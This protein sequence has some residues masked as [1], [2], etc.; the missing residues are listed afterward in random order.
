[1]PESEFCWKKD[2]QDTLFL[3]VSATRKVSESS[4]FTRRWREIEGELEGGHH[5]PSPCLG[6]GP[7]LAVPRCGEEA[8]AHLWFPPLAYFTPRNPNTQRSVAEIFRRLC[9]TENNR[10]K[11]SPAG[12]NLPGKFL[13]GGR[14]SSPSSP[15]SSWTSSGSSFSSSPPP[16][17]SSPPLHFVPL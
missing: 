12:R 11:S 6:T 7:P 1:M 5:G 4:Y 15:S 10:E 17:P 2:C 8:L 13:P 14:K 16:A 3:K 9:G